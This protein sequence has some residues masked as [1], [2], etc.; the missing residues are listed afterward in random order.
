VTCGS[1]TK[2]ATYACIGDHR[3]IAGWLSSR[4]WMR[5]A[6]AGDRAGSVAAAASS[7][8]VDGLMC[9]SYPPSGPGRVCRERC[10]SQGGEP[11]DRAARGVHGAAEV[12]GGLRRP[13]VRDGQTARGVG[14]ADL[15]ELSCS[16][17]QGPGTCEKREVSKGSWGCKR[18]DGCTSCKGT[19][20]YGDDDDYGGDPAYEM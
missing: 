6:G 9:R 15:S 8:N 5:R 10:S 14:G 20:E 17:K 3:A 18:L 4:A 12:E 1:E 13:L 7:I 2:G 11:T 19:S 16:C